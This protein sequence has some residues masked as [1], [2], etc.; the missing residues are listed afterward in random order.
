MVPY[1]AANTIV[2]VRVILTSNDPHK[3]LNWVEG[4]NFDAEISDVNQ[5]I[6]ELASQPLIEGFLTKMAEK[7]AELAELTQKNE[8]RDRGHWDSQDTGLT[9]GEHFGSLDAEGKRKYLKTRD[10]RVEKV[11]GP[12]LEPG[13]SK[14]IR[15][16]ID[17]EDH[18]TFPYPSLDASPAS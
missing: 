7:A 5:D 18:G 3:T 1:D 16:I 10:I 15:V 9:V 2:T 14:G 12:P 13:A 11:T 8:D 4:E 17:G 6:R